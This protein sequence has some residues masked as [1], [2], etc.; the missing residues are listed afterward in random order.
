MS[1][2]RSRRAQVV[3][4]VTK[5]GTLV[6]E[7]MHPQ[8]H[9]NRLQSLA[10]AVL[11]PGQESRLHRHHKSEEVYHVT[12]G[13]GHMTLGR[14]RFGVRAE[15]TVSIA[16][17]MPHRLSNNGSKALHVLCCCAPPYAHDDTELL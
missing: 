6:R 12:G 10:E 2:G 4:Y 3:P 11:A 8:V 5:D 13:E 16:P 7:L 15:D 17:G 14:D 1:G 9:G